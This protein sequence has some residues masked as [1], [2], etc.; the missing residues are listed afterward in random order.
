MAKK[1]KQHTFAMILC[2]VLLALSMGFWCYS[3][4]KS[5]SRRVLFA[6]IL[7]I[8]AVLLLRVVHDFFYARG[9]FSKKQAMQFYC[10]CKAAGVN[11]ACQT[12]LK[13]CMEIYREQVSSVPLRY[14]C[15]KLVFYNNIFEEGKKL[16]NKEAH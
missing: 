12:T 5:G 7:L 9:Y 1:R 11:S 2:G 3:L 14:D 4:I 8:L 13:Q 6:T 10:A 15:K 16:Y